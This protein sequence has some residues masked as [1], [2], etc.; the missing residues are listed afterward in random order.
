[1]PSAWP[2]CHLIRWTLGRLVAE[3]GR[4]RSSRRPPAIS[5]RVRCARPSGSSQSA[6]AAREGRGELGRGDARATASEW[7]RIDGIAPHLPTRISLCPQ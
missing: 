5:P 4:S 6:T 2:G 7:E 3:T 1:M